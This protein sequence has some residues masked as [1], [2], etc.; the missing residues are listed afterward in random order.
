MN[1]SDFYYNLYHERAET[2]LHDLTWI[3]HSKVP[4]L[5]FNP[6]QFHSDPAGYYFFPSTFKP[7]NIWRSMPYIF[8]AKISPNARILDFKKVSPDEIIRIAKAAKVEKQLKTD[9]NQYPVKDASDLMDRLWDT[10]R[11]GP[12]ISKPAAFNKL[13]RNLGYDAIFDDTKAIHV[14]EEQLIVLNPRI[15]TSI[16]MDKKNFGAYEKIE[17]I[18][19]ELVEMC[20]PHGEV[21][22]TKPKNTDNWGEKYITGYVEVKRGDNYAYFSVAKQKNESHRQTV[23][24][25]L[26]FS[27]P[28]LGYGVGAS[29]DISEDKLNLKEMKRSVQHALNKILPITVKES[30]NDEIEAQSDGEHHT[31][32]DEDSRFWGNQGA[33]IIIHCNSTKRYLLGL[34]SQY[35][36]EPGTWNLFG[37][38]IDEDENPKEAVLREMSEELGLEKHIPIRLFDIFENG[39]FKFYNFYGKVDNEFNPHLN[40]EH[41]EARWFLKEEFPKNLHFGLKRIISKLP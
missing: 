31:S 27:R 35:V 1:F 12:F 14:A 33:G 25:H 38:A 3:H 7:M 18:M 37:G 36:N 9:I 39:S 29:I 16:S 17:T 32:E 5:K 24:I 40:W 6:S 21:T 20:K 10:M 30:I 23:Y 34:R 22:V 4:Y 41:T 19:N 15:I 11:N 26:K 13:F 8:R 2:N 28:N